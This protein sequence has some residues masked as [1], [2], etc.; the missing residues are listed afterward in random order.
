MHVAIFHLHENTRTTAFLHQD[1]HLQEYHRHILM[2]PLIIERPFLTAQNITGSV[3]SKETATCGAACIAI[4][5]IGAT[6]LVSMVAVILILKVQ[7]TRLQEW[8]KKQNYAGLDLSTENQE[9]SQVERVV[10]PR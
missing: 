4:S 3:A 5:V 8:L 10:S 6:A 2:A 9:K 1:P 7:W